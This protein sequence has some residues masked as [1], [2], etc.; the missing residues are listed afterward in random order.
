M[1]RDQMRC[2]CLAAFLIAASANA[3]TTETK[4]STTKST[5]TDSG[6]ESTTTTQ[7]GTTQNSVLPGIGT[8]PNLQEK[9]PSPRDPRYRPPIS[10]PGLK[11][12]TPGALF[13][14]SGDMDAQK[15][16]DSRQQQ[17][18][19]KATRYEEAIYDDLPPGGAERK[20]REESYLRQ[21]GLE[22]FPYAGPDTH[23]HE[24]PARRF[25]IVFFISLPI[26][27]AASYGIFKL[28]SG[29]SAFS[30]GQTLG[31]LGLGA[32]LSAGI[33][34][35]DYLQFKQIEA[36]T[37]PPAAFRNSNQAEARITFRY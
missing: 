30:R 11:E 6:R 18:S 22:R 29:G 31:V 36:R 8:A 33:G 35:Y 12:P 2:L 3:Q 34:Y 28:G 24:S 13:L 37:L 10:A 7:P 20:R 9:R 15:W 21:F 14:F 4:D 5:V 27:M 1:I 32:G 19:R 17:N 23:E 16:M 25:Q 26:T